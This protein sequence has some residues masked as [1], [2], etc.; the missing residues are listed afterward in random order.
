MSSGEDLPPVSAPLLQDASDRGY[1]PELVDLLAQEYGPHVRE[2]EGRL[3]TVAARDGLEWEEPIP[4][5]PEPP[6]DL[7]S[8]ILPS[9][10]RE[11]VA[12][13]AASKQVATALP[14]G[15]ALAA[16]STSV[17]GKTE[18]FVRSG[19]PPIPLNIYTA[20][21]LRSAERKSP[22][23]AEMMRPIREWERKQAEELGPQYRAA[24][25]KK[26]ALKKRLNDA[27][28]ALS[29]AESSEEEGRAL[30]ELNRTRRRIEELEV[31]L[32]PRLFTSDVTEEAL[33]S[34]MADQHG[35]A[36]ILSSEGDVLRIFAGR[37]SV[38]SAP[39]LGLLKAGWS[40]DPYRA[41]RVGRDG[42]HLPRPLLTVGLTVQPTLLRTLSNRD[43]LDGEGVLA[44]FLWFAPPSMLGKRKTG[45]EVPELDERARSRYEA[46][47]RRLLEA[48]PAEVDE[49]G[50]WRPHRLRLRP[51]ARE[52]LYVWEEKVEHE[53]ADGGDLRPVEAW[54]GK[55]VGQTVRLA[56]LLHITE[57]AGRGADSFGAPVTERSMERAVEIARHLIPHALYVLAGELEMDPE[58]ELARYVLRRVREAGDPDLTERD[59][60]HLTKGK[61]EINDM[62]DLREVVFTLEAHR[63]VR[64]VKRAPTGGRRASPWIRLNPRARG[65]NTRSTRS[66]PERAE[67]PISGTSGTLHGGA[68]VEEGDPEAAPDADVV[69]IEL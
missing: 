9:P 68:S 35:R 7:P 39:S 34:L 3:L 19:W 29:K 66:P 14:L 32:P 64:K 5:G 23:E 21:V 63:L 43:V 6:A 37:Y 33:G 38:Q 17:A 28:R 60:W 49:S 26:E 18:V 27:K 25:D 4:L 20:A 22:T 41:D 10:L 54:G 67:E 30:E 15:L 11:H 50:Q 1:W 55:L 59:L 12:S 24:R 58:L 2:W 45:T 31:R 44:R 69:E 48:R 47:L 8:D 36:A 56:G 62:D 51:G 61:S 65:N 53:L 52:R 57:R 16:V 42:V 13:V 40:G 46:L